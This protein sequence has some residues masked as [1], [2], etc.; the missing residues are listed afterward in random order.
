MALK[1][2]NKLV[3]VDGTLTRPIPRKD[4]DFIEAV[5]WDMTNSMLCSWLFHV[6]NPKSC[7]SIA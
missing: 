2:K 6:I 1:V 5:A 4:E 3:F 7:M